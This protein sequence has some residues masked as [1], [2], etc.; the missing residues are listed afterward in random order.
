MTGGSL[1]KLALGVR[2]R[3]RDGSEATIGSRVLRNVTIAFGPAL[4]VIPL[5]G[6]VLAALTASL[7]IVTETIMLLTQGERL[8][9][10]LA[11]TAVF[12][13]DSLPGE[14]NPTTAGPTPIS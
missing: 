3:N 5:L 8:G 13:A 6:Y 10:K 11:G 4:L 7:L 12:R 2:V 9:D 14:V 1:G